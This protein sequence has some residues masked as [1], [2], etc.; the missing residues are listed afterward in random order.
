MSGFRDI[1]VFP[2]EVQQL[3]VNK[4]EVCPEQQE[5]SSRFNLEI[6][7]S[8]HVKEEPE[9][10]WS[11]QEGQ[12]FQ[13]QED[14]VKNSFFPVHVKGEDDEEKPQSSHLQQRQTEQVGTG[15]DGEDCRPETGVAKYFDPERDLHPETEVKTDESSDA[16]TDDS[17]DWREATEQKSGLKSVGKSTKERAKMEK[18]ALACSYCGKKFKYKCHLTNHMRIHTGEKPF[19]CSKCGKG[20]NHKSYVALHMRNCQGVKTVKREKLFSCPKCDQRF[21]R[22][23]LLIIH[24]RIHTGEKPFACPECGKRF[25]SQRYM[26]KHMAVHKKESLF[27]CSECGDTFTQKSSVTLH[28]KIHRG[29]PFITS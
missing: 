11:N 7:R 12:Q 5:K 9:E 16:E 3:S 24:M 28:M 20:F 27:S 18:K 13:G 2:V 14:D 19:S 6:P 10:L 1:S 25:I 26:T 8:L 23:D 15:T 17:T 4:A 29:E 22:Q 21:N